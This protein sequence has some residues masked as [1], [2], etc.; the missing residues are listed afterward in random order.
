MHLHPRPISGAEECVALGWDPPRPRPAR[1]SVQSAARMHSHPDLST[2]GAAECV[3]LR[4]KPPRPCRPLTAAA[5]VP[6]QQS[7][8]VASWKAQTVVL[9]TS[10]GCRNSES[11]LEVRPAHLALPQW[12]RQPTSHPTARHVG[13]RYCGRILRP[14]M[15]GH[16]DSRACGASPRTQ[17]CGTRSSPAP[18]SLLTSVRM[19]IMR[20]LA[21]WTRS[22]HG[23]NAALLRSWHRTRKKLP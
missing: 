18:H 13:P 17:C 4:Q 2:S 22:R 12:W 3:D 5:V 11:E 7:G 6:R 8:P 1:S 16:S 19:R 9:Q 20:Q 21:N 15:R 14:A 10:T 23:A